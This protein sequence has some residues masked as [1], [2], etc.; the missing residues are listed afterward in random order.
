MGYIMY[1]GLEDKVIWMGNCEFHS[2]CKINSDKRQHQNPTRISD[3]YRY[4]YPILILE[5]MIRGKVENA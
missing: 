5:F 3:Q 2:S 1:F 4:H